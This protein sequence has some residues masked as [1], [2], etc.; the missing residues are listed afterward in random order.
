MSVGACELEDERCDAGRQMA[1]VLLVSSWPIAVSF[2]L[3]DRPSRAG[4]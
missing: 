4:F 1:V 3:R 2:L